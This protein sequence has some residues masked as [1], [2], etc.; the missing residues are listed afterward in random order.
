[1]TTTDPRAPAREFDHSSDPDFVAYYKQASLSAETRA[2]F[3]AVRDKVLALVARN[4][5]PG[6]R[7]KVADI[8][9][10]AG[11][12]AALW[13]QLGHEVCGL[14]V[15]GPLIAIAA[16]RAA[17]AGLPIRF[18]VGTA[19]ALPYGD[20]SMD[21]CLLPELL[22]HVEDWESCLREAAR[23]LKPGGVL[24]LSTTNVLCPVQQEFDLPLYS[25]YPRPLKR[26]YERLAVTTRPELV[27]HARYPAVHWF[28]FYGLRDYLAPFGFECLDRFDMVDA[29]GAGAGA[30]LALR[31]I[32]ALASLRWL[33]HV[34]T[35]YSVVFAIKNGSAG[36]SPAIASVGA[37]ANR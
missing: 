26:R 19:T 12:Q 27:N 6:T 29:T 30:R 11:S 8:G 15:N 23:V 34:A 28:S 35:P 33:G 1:M 3:E 16:Q 2:R 14:D 20:A 37:R 9:C 25:W 17:A 5:P 24:Y 36:R 31:A 18:D 7:L 13:A 32:R 10:G 21:V 22:E 4:R